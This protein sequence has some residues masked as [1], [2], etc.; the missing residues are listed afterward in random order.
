MTIADAIKQLQNHA[1][2]THCA[3]ALW[4]PQDV[5]DMAE[6]KKATLTFDE[7][8]DVLDAV[9]HHQDASIGINWNVLDCHM[10]AKGQP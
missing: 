7:A 4:T 3:F 8:N 6:Q 1:P 5:Y 10:P 2:D 9:H